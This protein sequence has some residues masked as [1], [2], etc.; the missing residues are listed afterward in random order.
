MLGFAYSQS[1]TGL[2]IAEI[3]LPHEDVAFERPDWLGREITLG[4]ALPELKPDNDAAP[5]VAGPLVK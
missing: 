2:V 4:P 3:E 1:L 5:E